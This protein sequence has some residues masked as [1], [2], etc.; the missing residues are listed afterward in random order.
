MNCKQGDLAI[1]IRDI[2][3]TDDERYPGV[4]FI[5]KTAGRIV[6]C[7]RLLLDGGVP[8]WIL[9]TPLTTTVRS[10]TFSRS[11]DV[12]SIDDSDLR[13]LRDAPGADETLTWAGK[14]EQHLL[15]A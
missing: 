1:C 13:P 14:P 2:E 12:I 7:K 8:S 9:E 11:G 6:Q 15:P 10:A 4:D 3:G 5:A